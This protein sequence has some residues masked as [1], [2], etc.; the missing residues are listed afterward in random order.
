MINKVFK[1]S[2]EVVADIKSGKSISVG[3]FSLCGVP[4]NLVQ[5]LCQR[6]VRNLTM[7]T[8]CTGT[9]HKGVGP[10]FL[11]KQVSTVYAT[12]IGANDEVERQ[13]LNGELE[14]NFIPIGIFVEKLR[15]SS[16]GILGFYT[17]TGADS[18]VETGG[19]PTKFYRGGKNVERTSL[20]K[21]FKMHK[22]K[23]YLY[24]EAVS[25][26]F[27]LVKAWKADPM[28]NL[29]FRRTAR[30]MNMDL[31]GTAKVTIAEVEEIV[32]VGEL[33][34]DEI[35]VPGI[36][37]NRVVKGE[38][39]EKPFENL[40]LR[41]QKASKTPQSPGAK[42]RETIARRAT[43]EI[44]TG[45]CVNLGVGI[46]TLIT[47]YVPKGTD[48]MLHGENGLLGIGPYPEKGQEDP[49]NTNAG[50]ESITLAKGA[51]I[52]SMTTSF[53]LIR[54][55]H[56]DLTCVGALQ[57]SQDGDFASWVVPGKVVRGMG[58]AMDLA[59][60]TSKLVVCMEHTAK[61]APRVVEKCTLPI[62]G[63]HAVDMLITEL[64]VFE[65]RNDTGMTLIE[66]ADGYDLDYV[67][68]HTTAK[69]YTPS[70]IVKMKQNWDSKGEKCLEDGN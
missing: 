47:E 18:V 12:Y 68:K 22:G 6:D 59:A 21:T 35:H 61:G 28:G 65:F 64:A 9:T 36:L 55:G 48:I 38:K 10:L 63:K 30:N 3:G 14:V 17:S 7:Y 5:A 29:V 69:F 44:K 62:T 20:P 50:K 32:G 49:D 23:K 56:L 31:P 11:N 37:V 54:G 8:L 33:D 53:G 41:D 51:S 58:G 45:M 27:A 24:E 26:D 16:T 67:R 1:S 13:Y 43:F 60:S 19:F 42:A 70:K 25:T 40:I 39:Y 4:E 2:E 66:I 15:S 57:V 46:P 52:F 34:P